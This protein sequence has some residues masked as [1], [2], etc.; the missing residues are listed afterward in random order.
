MPQQTAGV[1]IQGL[2]EVTRAMERAGVDV[3][4]LKDVMGGIAA[5]GAR[6]M[7][8]FAPR[9]SGALKAS[10]RGNRAKGK[11]V[12]TMGKARVPYAAPIQWGWKARNIKPARI[13]E[14]TDDVMED[15]VVQR[16]EE[17]WAEIAERHS[18]T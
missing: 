5:E 18:L 2:R 17:G 6:V 3:E 7:E 9:R 8:G 4:E 15:R 11:A 13:V 12:V 14:R 10:I 16:L 1:Y